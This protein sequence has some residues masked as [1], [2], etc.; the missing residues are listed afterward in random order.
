M[1]RQ[2]VSRLCGES[3]Q[4]AIPMAGGDWLYQLTDK[5]LTLDSP[6]KGSST[7]RMTT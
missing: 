1:Q 6:S 4:G 3:L 7:T 5:G 2:A